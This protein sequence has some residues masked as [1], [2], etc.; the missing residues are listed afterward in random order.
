MHSSGRSGRYTNYYRC[1]RSFANT[2]SNTSKIFPCS[3]NRKLLCTKTICPSCNLPICTNC[4][5][6]SSHKFTFLTINKSNNFFLVSQKFY[7][8]PTARTG[9]TINKI[10]STLIADTEYILQRLFHKIV[11]NSKNVQCDI[12]NKQNNVQG[13]NLEIEKQIIEQVIE[14]QNFRNDIS[15]ERNTFK[16]VKEQTM[17]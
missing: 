10:N 4:F 9:T 3:Q 1:E 8:T 15:S 2:N 14:F 16:E 5:Y 6:L 13:S 11:A 12:I 17:R 7:I